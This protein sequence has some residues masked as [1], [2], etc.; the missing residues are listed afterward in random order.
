MIMYLAPSIRNIGP[1]IFLEK[2]KTLIIGDLHLG[3]ERALIEL[4]AFIH[5]TQEE[6]TTKQLLRILSEAN[7][8]EVV[9][10]G[11]IKHEFGTINKDEWAYTKKIIR[12]LMERAGSIVIIRGNHDNLLMPI[13]SSM[14]LEATDHVIR[15]NVLITHGDKLIKTTSEVNTIIIGHEHPAVM[16]DDGVRKENYKAFI[17]GKYGDKTIIV[18]PSFYPLIEGSDAL[19]EEALGPY[20]KKLRDGEAYVIEGEETFYFGPLKSLQ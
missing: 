4:G 2:T 9:L 6:E 8:K 10:N 3:A 7:P 18:M 11:D 20:M 17:K 1:S 14:G 5:Q 13:I 16:L 12:L 19:R 15:S